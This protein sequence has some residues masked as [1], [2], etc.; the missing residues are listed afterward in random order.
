MK[1]F[2]LI[3][4]LKERGAPRGGGPR[5]FHP[6]PKGQ[7]KRL[8]CVPLLQFACK[9]SERSG[10]QGTGNLGGSAPG[11]EGKGHAGQRF[12]AAELSIRC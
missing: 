8:T 9:T 12:P 11:P 10:F 4:G 2:S 1:R 5:P 6:S 3:L 7:K